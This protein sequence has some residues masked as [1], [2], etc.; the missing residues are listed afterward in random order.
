M[1]ARVGRGWGDGE[2]EGEGEG[3]GDGEGD[4]EGEGEGDGDGEVVV[5]RSRPHLARCREQ[6]RCLARP[7]WERRAAP[8]PTETTHRAAHAFSRASAAECTGQW[9][10][11]WAVVAWPCCAVVR[12][13]R[14]CGVCGAWA[15]QWCG[16]EARCGEV[17]CSA[18]AVR[19][20][21]CAVLCGAVQCSAVRCC[22]VR[23]PQLTSQTTVSFSSSSRL[24]RRETRLFCRGLS[25]SFA[26]VCAAQDVPLAFMCTGG[27]SISPS[28]CS[29]VRR[30]LRKMASCS[31]DMAVCS[32]A[33]GDSVREALAEGAGSGFAEENVVVGAR[34]IRPAP[35]GEAPA[36]GATAPSSCSAFMI[37]SSWPSTSLVAA[38]AI[39]SSQ[40]RRGA[41]HRG[42]LHLVSAL[43]GEVKRNMF[44]GLAGTLSGALISNLRHA[45][46]WDLLRTRDDMRQ[47][48]R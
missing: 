33:V 2:G 28:M 44:D 20:R 7:A 16:G 29:R 43:E 36:S 1:R 10:Q 12:C 26:A 15:V 41:Q 4:G 11:A 40:W 13:V 30:L 25:A 21:C 14:W 34:M 23:C 38:S 31:A 47:T 37:S 48:G 9:R 8:A 45:L 32:S 3:D 27:D 46:C 39:A 22:A 17:Q 35:R 18:A 24:M 6:R 42:T 19:M 5:R